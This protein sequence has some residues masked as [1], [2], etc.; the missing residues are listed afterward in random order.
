MCLFY[1]S[2]MRIICGYTVNLDSVTT[3]SGGEVVKVVRAIADHGLIERVLERVSSPREGIYDVE[4]F[5]LG[6]LL[7]MQQGSGAEWLIFDRNVFDFLKEHFLEGSRVIL[8]GNSG[9]MANVLSDLGV[10]EVVINTPCH[11][12]ELRGLLGD[13]VRIP[14]RADGRLVLAHPTDAGFEGVD[15]VGIHFVFNFNRG[16]RVELGEMAFIVPH[17]DRFIATYDPANIALAMNPVFEEYCER[18]APSFDGAILSGFHLL[19]TE[20]SDGTTYRDKIDGLLGH[21]GSWKDRNPR[22]FVHLELGY[23]HSS[24]VESYLLARLLHVDSLGMNEVELARSSLL[25][26]KNNFKSRID[27]LDIKGIVEGASSILSATDLKRVCVH[28]GEFVVSVFERG[29]IDPGFEA[30]ALEFGIKAAASYAETGRHL[31]R[32][33]IEQVPQGFS[34]SRDGRVEV[35]KLPDLYGG[36]ELAGGSCFAE[37]GDYCVVGVPVAR[38]ETPVTTVGLGDTFTAATFL[39]ELELTK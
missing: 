1:S 15:D 20:Y 29:F 12:K 19:L 28:T 35:S 21:V 11:S 3:I 25:K 24:T 5:F 37:I 14:K 32:D 38:C 31:K 33:R 22:L 18:F 39:R 30:Q 13:G 16:S 17:D 6:L 23:F 36:C 10:G 9:N 27:D 34:L 26:D 8:G 4:D 2:I 7:S